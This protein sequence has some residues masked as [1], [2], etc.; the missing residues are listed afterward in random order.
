[1]ARPSGPAAAHDGT[2]RNADGD[3]AGR[4]TAPDGTVAKTGT[5]TVGIAATNGVAL[6]ADRRASLGGR[7]VAN[8]GVDKVEQVH[9]SA[10]MTL[11][12]SV[13]D[14]QAVVRQLRSEASLYEARRGRPLSMDALARVAGDLLRGA[15]VTPVLG[16]VDGDG[17]HVYDLDGGGGVMADDYAATGSGMQVAYGVLERQYE[18]DADLDGAVAA[19]A[20]A[21]AAASERDTASGNGVL[22]ARVTADGV[23]FETH[24]DPTEVA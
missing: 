4:R 22:V 20:D 21:V 6:A 16:G 18:P 12:G 13:G 14:A 8:K 7:F 23:A 24:D 19:A 15:P 17:T 11:S 10:A 5:T 1:M 2:A 9:P 3:G